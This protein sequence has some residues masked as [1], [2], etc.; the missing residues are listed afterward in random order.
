[1]PSKRILIKKI[2]EK[3]IIKFNEPFNIKI[4]QDFSFF[5]IS[6]Y[7]RNIANEESKKPFKIF[8]S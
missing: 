4:I 1:M 6:L 8:E 3:L 5:E 7:F 2:D